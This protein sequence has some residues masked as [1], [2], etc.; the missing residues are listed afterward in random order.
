VYIDGSY[1]KD[2]ERCFTKPVVAGKR[3]TVLSLEGRFRLE[4]RK[5]LFMMRVVRHCTD[6]QEKLCMPLC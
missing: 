2:R 6:F 3:T 1:K 5:K 4:I